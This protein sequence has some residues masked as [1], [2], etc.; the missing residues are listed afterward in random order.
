MPDECRQGRDV[1]AVWHCEPRSEIIPEGD[2]KL[3]A[4]L[5]EAEEGIAAVATGVASC[6]AADLA[7]GDLAAD[8]V[9]R[10]VGVQWDFGPIEHHEQLALVGSM[11]P[12][13]QTVE[14]DEAGLAREDA[15]EACP[16][17]DLAL[18]GRMKAIGFEI[19]IEP[20]D[21]R[22]GAALGVALL[23]GKGVELVDQVY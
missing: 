23:V 13:E 2:A 5:A 8:I 19:A 9:L 10:S 16:Q 14:G 20:P 21:Q 12:S 3:C 11:E 15:I 6:A 18:L 4:G 7:L 22:T 1:D 17:S